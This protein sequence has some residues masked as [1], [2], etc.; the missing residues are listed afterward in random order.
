MRTYPAPLVHLRQYASQTCAS[1]PSDQCEHDLLDTASHVGEDEA[2]EVQSLSELLSSQGWRPAQRQELKTERR[3]FFQHVLATEPP[4]LK[5]YDPLDMGLVDERDV[6]R[7]FR[8][9]F[10]AINPQQG[11]S[12]P[13][14][15]TPTTV[16]LTSRA[17]FITIIAVAASVDPHPRSRE[18]H[19]ALQRCMEHAI[20]LLLASNAKSPEV[21]KTLLLAYLFSPK[22]SCLAEDKCWCL[23][24]TAAR[25][26]NEIGLDQKLRRQQT[27]IINPE[28]ASRS[29]DRAWMFAVVAQ[30]SLGTLSGM[31]S[32]NEL[33][34]SWDSLEEWC[35]CADAL[36]GDV[37]LA[38]YLSLR[39]ME[40]RVRKQIE[41]VKE[42][43]EY[44]TAEGVRVNCNGLFD[45]WRS[46]WVDHARLAEDEFSR[47][48]LLTIGLHIQLLLNVTLLSLERDHKELQ[49][50]SQ[51]TSDAIDKCAYL[52]T[53]LCNHFLRSFSGRA[54]QLARHVGAMITWSALVL[55]Q[56][57]SASGRWTIACRIALLLAG[58]AGDLNRQ[59]NFASFYGR[60]LLSFIDHV[61]GTPPTRLVRASGGRWSAEKPVV[62]VSPVFGAERV[63]PHLALTDT[64]TTMDRLSG[65]E[66]PTG[67]VEPTEV[68]L[69]D[70]NW[71]SQ[72]F[73]MPKDYQIQQY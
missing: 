7:L 46:R 27:C 15:D 41:S 53:E 29:G 67:M 3:I 35:Q 42:G 44:L 43:S 51:G 58:D 11:L 36:L 61:V 38:A 49:H 6:V 37:Q 10:E 19:A 34:V 1:I 57:K 62:D 22:P 17:L 47:A 31:G 28:H 73:D 21:V 5:E 8:V 9:Y 18:K 14:V 68:D 25:I 56:M 23:V 50:S 63:E 66:A 64:S 33:N 70:A 60:L 45:A 59:H 39:N 32:T 2:A 26:A 20:S 69:L 13:L 48:Y 24:D 55:L 30:Q 65:E 4:A 52:A 54:H 16:R 12:D 72:F 40:C 71:F